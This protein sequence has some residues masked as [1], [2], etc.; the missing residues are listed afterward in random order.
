[1]EKH[2]RLAQLIKPIFSTANHIRNP[3][4]YYKWTYGKQEMKKE[5][6]NGNGIM[7]WKLLHGSV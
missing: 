7:K 5:D 3:Y 4:Q 6:G 1:M 2:R